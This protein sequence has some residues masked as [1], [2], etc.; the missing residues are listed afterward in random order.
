MT[1]PNFFKALL[2]TVIVGGTAHAKM[3]DAPSEKAYLTDIQQIE[4]VMKSGDTEGAATK[5]YAR[6]IVYKEISPWFEKHGKNKELVK[7]AYDSFEKVARQM[8]YKSSSGQQSALR[9]LDY[10]SAAEKANEIRYWLAGLLKQQKSYALAVDQYEAIY[11]S[12]KDS[13]RASGALIQAISTTEIAM[14]E[15]RKQ[16]GLP[17]LGALNNVNPKSQ[18]RV[19]YS[20]SETRL[21]RLMSEFLEKF[22]T[23]QKA[24]EL[25]YTRANLWYLH[26]NFEDA[27]TEMEKIVFGHQTYGKAET[28]AYQI[29]EVLQLNES[30]DKTIDF[31][32]K[33][34]KE[35]PNGARFRTKIGQLLRSSELKRIAKLELEQAFDAAGNAYLSYCREYGPQDA[36]LYEKALYRAGKNFSISENLYMAAESRAKY[37]ALFPKSPKY[38]E[39]MLDLAQNQAQLA[40]FKESATLYLSFSQK[41]SKH[42]KAPQALYRA[43]LFFWGSE[44]STAAEQIFRQVLAADPS[45]RAEAEYYLSDIYRAQ[46]NFGKAVKLQLDE[47]GRK[48]TSSVDYVERTLTIANLEMEKKGAYPFKW[49]E[50]AIKAA[51]K[52][53]KALLNTKKGRSL[54]A[55]VLFMDLQSADKTFYRKQLSLL[56][57]SK[58]RL[59]EAIKKRGEALKALDS[60]YVKISKLISGEWSVGATYK[61]AMAH[62]HL[63]LEL[64]NSPAPRK[65]KGLELEFYQREIQDTLIRPSNERALVLANEC[66]DQSRE[67]NLFSV[68]TARCYG[69]ASELDP[70]NFPL[71]RT[72][73]LPSLHVA[74][75]Q[76][77][78]KSAIKA[79]EPTSLEHSYFSSG[80]F[81]VAL[82]GRNKSRASRLDQYLREQGLRDISKESSLV[83]TETDYRIL[84]KDRSHS[85]S[86]ELSSLTPDKGQAPT[87]SYLNAL[88]SSKPR[89]AVRVIREQIQK[90]PTNIALHNLLGLA[91]LE[92][93]E[94]AQAETVWKAVLFRGNK[95]PAVWNNLGVVYMVKG[96]EEKAIRYFKEATEREG[97]PEALVNLGFLAL[98][99]RNG[100]SARNYFEQAKT[101]SS[102]LS[103]LEVGLTVAQIQNRNLNS[104][105]DSM[106]EM[107]KRL[108]DDPYAR[109]SVGY[110]LMD[111]EK[112]NDLAEQI[113]SDYLKERGTS[114]EGVS[115]FERAIQEVKRH[116]KDVALID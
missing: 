5:L 58:S 95:E 48:G 104:L 56:D 27:M 66:L 17:V 69:L 70:E 19:P 65:L 108:K 100:G 67:L 41:F 38:Q 63:A 99:Y 62:R 29:L 14:E 44:D 57:A 25:T 94:V 96:E 31:S 89:E 76:P 93:G 73:F 24:T 4:S 105:H 49:I 21:I 116:E 42:P 30:L 55:K 109:L 97:A 6:F 115:L 26:R 101:A 98:K 45:Q 91:H 71:A 113:F 15:E 53:Q 40:R 35:G 90:N 13:T 52:D 80:I 32:K 112:E 37:L 59:Q 28:A 60:E 107:S 74:T 51:K 2:L 22:P 10:F 7:A 64:Q 106:L 61:N 88:R 36:A 54:M 114:E 103:T 110:Y 111:V 39:V 23:H 83:P 102:Q 46:D 20:D 78:L 43:G 84:S 85:M 16:K 82:N 75:L 47:R 11:K 77:E 18:E 68:W 12:E 8:V 72:F 3:D 79:G 34:L 81:G 86:R 50:Q 1:K 33:L 9:Y 87:L 92:M